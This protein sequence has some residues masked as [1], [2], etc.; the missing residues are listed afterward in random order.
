MRRHRRVVRR[1]YDQVHRDH[2]RKG[3]LRPALQRRS[4]GPYQ[5][6]QGQPGVRCLVRRSGRR[7]CRRRDEG[8]LEAYTSPERGCH[9]G[10]VQGP[11][12][13]WTGVY[14]GALGFCSNTKVLAEKKLDASHSWQDLLNPELAED[15]GYGAPVYLRHRLH[16]VVDTGQLAGGAGKAMAYMRKLHPNILQYTKSGSAP[17]ADGRA[18]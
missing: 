2:R 8:L 12:G 6:R 5:G 1:D 18:W 9:P 3:G 7:L 15:I 16:D 13:F 4:A 10:E 14:V 11:E 17:G